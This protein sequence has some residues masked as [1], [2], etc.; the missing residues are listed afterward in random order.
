M[1]TS[2]LSDSIAVKLFWEEEGIFTTFYCTTQAYSHMRY[3]APFQ[4][5]NQRRDRKYKPRQTTQTF[6]SGQL[7]ENYRA[8]VWSRCKRLLAH[9]CQ[10]QSGTTQSDSFY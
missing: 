1:G 6:M 2:I 8:R 7:C 4:R 5:P 3:N 9:L 10:K